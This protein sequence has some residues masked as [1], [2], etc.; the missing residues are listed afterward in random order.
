MDKRRQ[1]NRRVRRAIAAAWMAL[2]KEK[3]FSEITV[4]DVVRRAGV[5]RQSYY[6]N[7]TCLEDVARAY[8]RE[9]QGETMAVLRAQGID[10]Y[11]PRFVTLVLEGVA[12]HRED[13][14]AMYDAGLSQIL[15]ELID[16]MCCQL[17]GDMPAR[18]V[19]RYR[20]SCFSGMLFHVEMTWLQSGAREPAAEV[21]ALLCSYET[22]ALLDRQIEPEDLDGG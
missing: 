14:L 15:L 19:E 4:T 18:S 1:E 21:A 20:I 13:L 16:Q 2:L 22:R 6:R 10:R 9:I 17:F 3:P 8:M 12:R 7:F 5:A 11:G